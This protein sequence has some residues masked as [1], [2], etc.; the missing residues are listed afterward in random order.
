MESLAERSSWKSSLSDS[1]LE[2]TNK[3]LLSAGILLFINGI[4][5]SFVS[6]VVPIDISNVVT[7]MFVTSLVLG[8]YAFVRYP[9]LA[10]VL[11]ESVAN[12]IDALRTIRSHRNRD[13][14]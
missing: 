14:L 9:P 11:L 8:C 4:G 13:G 7:V 5:L 12:G 10:H 6:A 2:Y 3:T 1:E